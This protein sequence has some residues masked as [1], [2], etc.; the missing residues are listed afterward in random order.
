MEETT[1]TID[2][3]FAEKLRNA[4]KFQTILLNKEDFQHLW[5]PEYDDRQASEERMRALK[6]SLVADPDFLRLREVLINAYPGRE[7]CVYAGWR[8][9]LAARQLNMDKIPVKITSSPLD[10]EK[11]RNDKDNHHAGDDIVEKRQA[12]LQ[13]LHEVGYDLSTLGLP[14]QEIVEVLDMTAADLSEGSDI[15]T[16]GTTPSKE[17]Q[18]PNCSHIGK[19]KDFKM[20]DKKED[21]NE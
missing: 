8:R 10:E 5:V 3:V 6:A 15:N 2:P 9:V 12:K 7:G 11:A 21:S 17:L 14:S 20:K 13:S 4:P 18:C 1:K 19:K 16:N